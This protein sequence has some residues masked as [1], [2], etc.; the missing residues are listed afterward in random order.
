MTTY[1]AVAVD[2]K[3]IKAPDEPVRMIDKKMPQPGPNEALVRIYLRPV[4]VRAHSRH[5]LT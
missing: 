5:G 4:R 2:E 3:N 1:K